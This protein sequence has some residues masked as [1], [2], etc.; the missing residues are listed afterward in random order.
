MTGVIEKLYQKSHA[1]RH[2]YRVSGVDHSISDIANLLMGNLDTLQLHDRLSLIE[3]W[4]GNVSEN[5]AKVKQSQ[6]QVVNY[7]GEI[8]KLIRENLK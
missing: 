3:D 7:M 1:L 8:G 4:I 5:M 2:E 6:Q